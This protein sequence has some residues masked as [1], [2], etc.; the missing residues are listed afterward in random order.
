[1]AL[2]QC[3]DVHGRCATRPGFCLGSMLLLL[4]LAGCAKHQAGGAGDAASA[5]EVGVL[6]MAPQK[7]VERTELSGRLS[8]LN[9]ADVRP[10]ISGIVQK[11]LFTEGAD[12]A[13]G[14]PLYQIDPAVYQATYDQAR[15]VLAKAEAVLSDAKAKSSRYAELVKINAVSKQDYD[16]AVAAVNEDQA[17]VL[18]D[19]ASLESA[20]INLGYTRITSP[21]SGQI[22]VSSVTAGAL[23]TA[24]QTT[25]LATVQ[26]IDRMYLDVTRPSID[27][28]RLRKAFNA[29]HLKRVGAQG[30]A[31][32]IVMEDGSDYAQPGTLAFSDITVDQTTGSVTLRVVVPNPEHELLPGM[33]VRADLEEGADDQAMLVPQL[34]VTRTPDGQATVWLAGADGKAHAATVKAETAYGDRWIVSQG[35]KIGDRVV[36]SG[37]SQLQDGAP[38]TVT[39]TH[40]SNAPAASGAA[41]HG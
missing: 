16:D 2:F 8:A 6:V 31:V 26:S 11:R 18:A 4:T 41:V 24:E 33:F 21:I 14:Q 15:G 23:V 7:I 27:W 37:A 9:V 40:A 5:T 32:H 13:A 34:A 22:G 30:A 25:A 1:M 10:Q 19:H 20:R 35:L 39:D 28:L 29:G 3:L 36:I 38:V 12:V 17:D